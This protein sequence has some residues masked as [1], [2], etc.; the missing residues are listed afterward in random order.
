M[1][2]VCA[3]LD[4]D[5]PIY[6]SYITGII[7]VCHHAQQKEFSNIANQNE[8]TELMKE[9]TYEGQSL[10]VITKELCFYILTSELK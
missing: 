5:V 3:S 2:L 9:L 8:S 1:F 6:A 10:N 4:Y 7:S